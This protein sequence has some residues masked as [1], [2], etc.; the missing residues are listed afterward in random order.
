MVDDKWHSIDL[1]VLTELVEMHSGHPIRI[2]KLAS[3]FHGKYDEDEVQQSLIR[4]SSD[5]IETRGTDETSVIFIFGISE[6]ARRA[7]G[8]WPSDADALTKGL[9]EAFRDAADNE[10]DREQAG[11]F[12][13]AA[14]A[15]GNVGAKA[16]T[17]IVSSTLAKMATG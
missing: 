2:D 12:R 7:V 16:I 1:P 17:E 14:N 3:V 15:L 6:R 9:L 5:Y 4:L 10:T 11:R 8:Q 13:Q